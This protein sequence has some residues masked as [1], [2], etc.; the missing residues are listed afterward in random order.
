MRSIS[1]PL[2][3]QANTVI[4]PNYQGDKEQWFMDLLYMQLD[5]QNIV[6]IY[7]DIKRT[8][9]SHV[10]FNDDEGTGQ[11]T[12]FAVLKAVTLNMS[13][14]TGYVQGMSYICAM[15]LTYLT[16]EESVCTMLSVM[17]RY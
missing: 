5:R 6:A 12:L 9:T 11:K 17:N 3:A 4:P 7:K 10:F 16:P 15:M 8:L 14:D 1:W 2:I 13:Q